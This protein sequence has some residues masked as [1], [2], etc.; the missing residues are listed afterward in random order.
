MTNSTTWQINTTFQYRYSNPIE[1]L[2]QEK[3]PKEVIDNFMRRLS[4][5]EPMTYYVNYVRYLKNVVVIFPKE[6]V[7]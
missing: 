4:R 2:E 5:Q 3:L 1:A 6:S 7:Y